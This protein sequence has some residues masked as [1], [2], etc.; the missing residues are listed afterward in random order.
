ML[1]VDLIFIV[2]L[3]AEA[4]AAATA[5]VGHLIII[6]IRKYLLF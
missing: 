4:V 1:I 2:N 3:C 6:I 5:S